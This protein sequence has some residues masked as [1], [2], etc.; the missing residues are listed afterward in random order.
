M[1]KSD[2]IQEFAGSATNTGKT[3]AQVAIL[4]KDVKSLTAHLKTHRKDFSTTRG[5][6]AKVQKMYKL[7]EYL[8]SIDKD[9]YYDI[10]QKLSIKDI[11]K[12]KLAAKS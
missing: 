4:H 9:R 6:T 12:R 8:Y 10:I 5:L 11:V 7:L 2:I 1:N 3:E